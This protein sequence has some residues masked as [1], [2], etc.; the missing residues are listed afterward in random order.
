MKYLSAYALAWLSGKSNPSVKDLETIIS[1]A[2]GSF[3][4]ARAE[5]L[6]ESLEERDLT[7]VIRSGL[8]KLQTSGGPVVA[9]SAQSTSAN[10]EVVETKKEEKKD[11]KKDEDADFDG[12]LD[13]FGDDEYIVNQILVL[14]IFFI[15]IRKNLRLVNDLI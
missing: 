11:D 13:M 14:S 12:A 4:K 1:A 8:T 15:Y 2:G 6:I 9:S 10:V 5:A 3:D 7:Q